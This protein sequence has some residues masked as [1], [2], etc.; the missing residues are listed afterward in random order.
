[1]NIQ[2]IS[3]SVS[4]QGGMWPK[5]PQKASDIIARCKQTALDL[6]GNVDF[7]DNREL[8][9]KIKDRTIDLTNPAI[10]RA[11]MGATALA[12]QPAIDYSNKAVDKET[13]RISV[14]RT[15][16]KII[17]GTAVGILVR[18]SAHK[19]I[20]RMTNID[21]K[22]K[23]S[24]ALIPKN[25][26]DK[27]KK[28]NTLLNNYRSALSTGMAIL[29]MCITNFVIDAPLTVY[30]TNKFK[31]WSETSKEKNGNRNATQDLEVKHE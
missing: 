10:N 29:A 6:F 17:A 31:T 25:F 14:C 21:S 8:I 22:A 18:G 19:L 30:L 1:M 23:L 5:R 24:Q 7:K 16:A 4:M 20:G 11:I 13:R 9:D 15:L 3:N 27:F 2:P 12:L 28:D 26:I